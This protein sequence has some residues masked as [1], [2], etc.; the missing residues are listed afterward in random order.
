[1]SPT[2]FEADRR[3]EACS[4]QVSQLRCC[5]RRTATVVPSTLVYSIEQKDCESVTRSPVSSSNLASVGYD[6][7][8]SVLEVEFKNGSVYQYLNVPRGTYDALLGAASVGG[9]FN[10]NVRDVFTCIRG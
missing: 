4:P 7:T 5:W 6:M 2:Q 10:A 3:S 1:M 9:Y 8:S